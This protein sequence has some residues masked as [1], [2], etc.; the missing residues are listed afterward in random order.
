[1]FRGRLHCLGNQSVNTALDR[2]IHVVYARARRIS[3]LLQSMEQASAK[4][5]I[6]QE[7]T[8]PLENNQRGANHI[9]EHRIRVT[10]EELVTKSLDE[11]RTGSMYTEILHQMSVR[12]THI[13]VLHF[14][15]LSHANLLQTGHMSPT[16]LNRHP[17]EVRYQRNGCPLLH[18]IQTMKCEYAMRSSSHR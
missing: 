14:H 9:R 8:R 1:M 7:G 10:E 4:L 17:K 6:L 11:Q 5:M 18:R 12:T 2:T 16:V 15:I 3:I 13:C